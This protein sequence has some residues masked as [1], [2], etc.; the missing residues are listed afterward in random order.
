[1]SLVA[2]SAAPSSFSRD[3]AFRKSFP[4]DAND[5]RR[6]T[7][8]PFASSSSRP[9]RADPGPAYALPSIR[10]AIPELQFSIPDAA[11]ASSTTPTRT[12]IPPLSSSSSSLSSL[13]RLPLAASPNRTDPATLA[14]TSEYVH[15]PAASSYKRQRLLSERDDDEREGR[16]G[17]DRRDGHGGRD[18]GQDERLNQVPRLFPVPPPPATHPHLE[19]PRE[20]SVVGSLHRGNEG[21]APAGNHSPRFAFSRAST[22]ASS[23]PPMSSASSVT[24]A[25][26]ANSV[27]SAAASAASEGWPS[28]RRY[29]PVHHL[30]DERRPAESEYR[31]NTGSERLLP[32]LPQLRLPE[33]E[34]PASSFASQPP[35]YTN[36]RCPTTNSSN[37]NSN[38]NSNSSSSSSNSN[39]QY[40]CSQ[41]RHHQLEDEERQQQP[42]HYR[43]QQH[44]QGAAPPSPHS[45]DGSPSSYGTSG[46]YH[47][48]H[49]SRMQSLSLGAIRGFD[50]A[51]FPPAD[52]SM[53]YHPHAAHATPSAGY[54]PPHSHHHHHNHHQHRHPRDPVSAD[55]F[56]RLGL[57][58]GHPMGVGNAAD[59]RGDAHSH[60]LSDAG[61]GGGVGVGVVG[62]RTMG[63]PKMQRKRR[64]NLPKE[65]TD[66]LRAWFYA[67]LHHPYPSEDEK[68]E[69]MRQ[70]GL[71]MNQISNWFINARR[72]HMPTLLNNARAETDAMSSSRAGR[73]RE[74]GHPSSSGSIGGS[75]D[76]HRHNVLPTTERFV[77]SPERPFAAPMESSYGPSRSNKHGSPLSEDGF[78]DPPRH[79]GHMK[80]GSV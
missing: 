55:E 71:Q 74:D 13:G 41:H 18:D 19:P 70:T 44:P 45:L 53:P 16:G 14:A 76:H 48:H 78:A 23:S 67:H 63:D 17:R 69:L 10:Q 30:E 26:V 75:S 15:A 54:Q 7:D 38:S 52:S 59:G 27:A 33:Y 79:H 40:S 25:T 11:Q 22:S 12:P 35:A 6:A 61:V 73:G 56:G 9:P 65:T 68:Q 5:A 2:M 64:G 62:A 31:S 37:S 28:S 3:A 29:P 21:A 24:T 46:A 42:Q 51:V 57:A 34:M 47:Q 20:R 43:H 32:R 50:R 60:G 39:Y 66:K 49:P 80:R 1:M 77:P 36:D 8:S 58:N 4:W 72:R